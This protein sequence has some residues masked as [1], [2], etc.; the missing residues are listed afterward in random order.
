MSIRTTLIVGINSDIGTALAKRFMRDGEEVIGTYRNIKAP[1]D[2]EQ[3]E[4][5]L[6]D[7][8]S[9][10]SKS[11]LSGPYTRILFCV[12]SP[13][14]LATY[15]NSVESS[16]DESFDLNGP[17]QLRFF[18]Y[19][20]QAKV[21]GASVCFLSAGGVNSTPKEFS[22]YTLGKTFLVK[23]CEL[24]A[25]EEPDLNIF[26]YGPGWVNTK[27]HDLMAERL[28]E[29]ER[30]AAIQYFRQNNKTFEED[31][32]EIYNDLSFLFKN[33]ANRVSGRNFTRGDKCLDPSYQEHHQHFGS[34][35]MTAKDSYQLRIKK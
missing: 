6:Q 35:Q 7:N 32:D 31:L 8:E 27:T 23:A 33:Q 30:K 20:E 1:I 24:I 22:A 34:V 16:W 13:T 21:P 14:P 18:R 29:G 10:W 3:Q 4:I 2:C 12:G 5:D 17:A 19:I 26:T 11:S 15:L 9:L 28:P 25:G